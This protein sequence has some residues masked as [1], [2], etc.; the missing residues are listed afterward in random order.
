MKILFILCAIMASGSVI[1]LADN[2]S[3]QSS[4]RPADIV[5]T[6]D[7]N[8]LERLGDM[9]GFKIEERGMGIYVF[10]KDKIVFAVSMH[11]DLD[12]GRADRPVE[13]TS[14]GRDGDASIKSELDLSRGV[15][16][17]VV[18]RFFRRFAH[19]IEG[20]CEKEDR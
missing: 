1:C 15:P 2:H 9:S 3:S 7:W 8:E 5:Y 19:R 16:R 6:L 11:T 4:G 10:T 13:F 18:K 12:T 14:H 20:S 17:R